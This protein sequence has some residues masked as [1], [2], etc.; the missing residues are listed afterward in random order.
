MNGEG[1][2][3]VLDGGEVAE[4]GVQALTVVED[5]DVLEDGPAGPVPAGPGPAVDQL[6]FE[7]REPA[8]GYSVVPALPGPG[9]AL[10]DP[11]G[12]KEGR[13]L[14]GGVLAA[15]VGIKPISV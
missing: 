8:L 5:L 6:V 1:V 15:P 7:G 2:L 3:L 11:V 13:E 4:R 12:V 10:D 14:P 9:E